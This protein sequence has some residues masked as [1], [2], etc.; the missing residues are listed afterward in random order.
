MTSYWRLSFQWFVHVYP[1]R[2]RHYGRDSVSNHQPHDCLLNR[3]FRRTSKKTSKLCVTGLCV[4]NSPGTCEFPAQTASNGE[5]VSIWRR[6]HGYEWECRC[7][8]YDDLIYGIRYHVRFYWKS[9]ST[10]RPRR[11]GYHAADDF[12]NFV[13]GTSFI[14][15]LKFVSKG[16]IDNKPTLAQMM[17]GGEQETGHHLNQWWSSSLI[18]VT[19][20]E[21]VKRDTTYTRYIIIDEI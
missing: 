10:L 9:C 15:S 20:T 13:N 1:L 5:N 16:P 8:L 3:L 18:C 12:C 19:R 17:A 7:L 6:L 2:W 4:W 11:N 14:L 21:W